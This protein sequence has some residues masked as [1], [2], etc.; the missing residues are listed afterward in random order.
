MDS[1]IRFPRENETVRIALPD[2]FEWS[3]LESRREAKV[4]QQLA[5]MAVHSVDQRSNLLCTECCRSLLCTLSW[6][7]CECKPGLYRVG[8]A[9]SFNI[10]L[11]A[12][13]HSA[14][15]RYNRRLE[16]IVRV[17]AAANTM[18]VSRRT[19]V[20][21]GED[22]RKIKIDFAVAALTRM[23][24]VTMFKSFDERIRR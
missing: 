23:P 19:N 24:T 16:S 5:L 22:V 9:G 21:L 6:L 4:N 14:R 11:A 7:S 2:V 3:T 13:T 8:T 18:E 20:A 10:S 12:L 17:S 1:F 15:S